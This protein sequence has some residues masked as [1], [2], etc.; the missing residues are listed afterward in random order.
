MRYDAVVFDMDGVLIRGRT[1]PDGIYRAATSDMLE[2]FGRPDVSDWPAALQQPGSSA[3]F[4]SA[5]E[6]FELPPELAWAYREAAATRIERE[7]IKRGDRG[8]FPDTDVLNTLAE[9]VNLG[10]ASNNRNALVA[11]CIERFGWSDIVGA[12][13]GRHPTLAE[14]DSRKPDPRFVAAAVDEL[15]AAAPLYVGDRGSDVSAADELGY[16]TALLTRPGVDVDSAIEPAHVIESLATL[17]EIV[18]PAA[19]LS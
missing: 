16:D 2:A 12:Y 18:V 8:R 6:A 5:C 1:T 15:D 7:W 9:N 17:E 10:V 3:S 11:H 19:G 14:F 4:V 13:R